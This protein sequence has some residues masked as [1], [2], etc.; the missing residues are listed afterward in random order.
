[1]KT[2][3]LKNLI[4]TL[5][6]IVAFFIVLLLAILLV[7]NRNNKINSNN[8]IKNNTI[9]TVNNIND[10]SLPEAPTTVINKKLK[11][12]DDNSLLCSISNNISNY[13]EYIRNRN[14]QAIKELGGNDL[15]TIKNNS[16]FITKQAYS[17]ENAYMAK[18]YVYG[19]LTVAN[20]DFTA[21][22]QDIYMIVYLTSENEGYKLQTISKEEFENMKVLEE[23]EKIDIEQGQYNVY[24]Y[25]FIDSVQLMQTYLDDFIFQMFN[26][27][28]K[29][30]EM[31]NQ[32]YREKRFGSLDAYVE[33]IN[34]KQEQ[35]RNIEIMQYKID[36]ED[37][38]TVYR[39]TDTNGNFYCI[40]TTSF[41][42]YEMILDSY[43]MDDYSNYN[44][45]SK[46]EKSIERFILM[47]DAAD[48]TN[49]YNLL[50]ETFRENNFPTREDFI[51]YV[52]SNWFKRNLIR[53]INILE[54][55]SCN[56][57]IQESISMSS[58]TIE[59]HFIVTLV[60]KMNFTIEFDI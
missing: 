36:K 5:I 47:I 17:T 25:E 33:Y 27:T 35:L 34:E 31:L 2:K 51:N 40:K 4:I 38:Y 29:S 56:V 48:Y 52:K 10:N 24:K 32:E 1:M 18:Y 19:V 57:I 46:K 15:Y 42:E 55:G 23:N 60:E 45:N 9:T 8:N 26:N 41:M 3:T 50:N 44:A 7:T 6:I 12:I 49:A 43:T 54:D 39:G 53:E 59:K 58:N 11:F 14:T 37:D 28:A 20:G 21:A 30:Y 16:K 13:F 22:Q